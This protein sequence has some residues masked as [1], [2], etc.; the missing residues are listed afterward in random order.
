MLERRE[1]GEGEHG[2]RKETQQQKGI[3]LLPLKAASI[4]TSPYINKPSVP[5]RAQPE[6]TTTCTTFG[7][8]HA[9]HS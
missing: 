6:A 2:A 1:E 4:D 5:L 3:G 8:Q 9:T 7:A